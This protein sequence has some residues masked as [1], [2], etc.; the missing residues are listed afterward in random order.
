[1]TKRANMVYGGWLMLSPQERAEVLQQIQAFA[2]ASQ[3]Q[4]QQMERSL[5][6]PPLPSRNVDACPCCNKLGI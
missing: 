5:R 3:Q 6:V 2:G 4:Q 1:M